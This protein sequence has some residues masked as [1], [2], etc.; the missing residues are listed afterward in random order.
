MNIQNEKQNDQVQELIIEICK[1]DYAEKVEN[2]LKKQRRTAQIPG[3]RVGNAPMGL[4]KRNYEKSYI[5]DIVNDMMIEELYKYM[6][7]KDLQILGEP[8]P[9]NEKTVVDFENPDKFIFA[10][11]IALEPEI[12][13]D[14]TKLSTITHYQI[15][16]TSDEIDEFVMNLRRRHGDY[17][18]PETAGETDFITVEYAVGDGTKDGNFYMNDLTDAGRKLFLNKN[19]NEIINADLNKIFDSE[20]KLIAFLKM[21]GQDFVKDEPRQIDLTIKYIGRLTPAEINEEFYKK[22]YPDGSVTNEEQ[23]KKAATEKIEAEWESHTKRYFMNEAIGILLKE[24]KME[25]PKEFLKKFILA[26]QKDITAEAL[27]EKYTEYENSFK[28]QLI[29][30][31]L[32]KENDI[33]VSEE[34]IKNYIR[35]YF[36]E[37]YFA[38]FSN[39]DVAERVDTLVNDAMKNKQDT[40][41]IYDQL[42]DSKLMDILAQKMQTQTQKVTFKEFT[43]AVQGGKEGDKK[44]KSKKSDKAE[45]PTDEAAESKPK[46]KAKKETSEEKPA[47][48]T[49]AKKSAKK[50]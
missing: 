32:A 44:G 49:K 20:A 11:E 35:Q 46:A 40:K 48:E 33:K 9:I 15:T 21:Q 47:K 27:D 25:L 34:E 4:I 31:K 14:Y 16:A 39:E 13:I 2:A 38:N 45:Q 24:V 6:R 17:S 1:E 41:N 29:E 28:W 12:N 37:N 18:S 26:S 43:E 23:M 10:F 7:E 50:E 42:F 3:F 36:M 30:N 8:L 22:A 19:K 5:A